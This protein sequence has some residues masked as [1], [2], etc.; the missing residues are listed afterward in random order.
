MITMRL[1]AGCTRSSV[2]CCVSGIGE[3]VFDPRM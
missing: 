1:L 2:C 3:P